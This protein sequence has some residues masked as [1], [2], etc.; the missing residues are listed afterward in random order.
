MADR[1]RVVALQYTSQD[2]GKVIAE[3]GRMNDAMRV[4]SD[5]L[6]ST[7]AR[8]AASAKA[9][10]KYAKANDAVAQSVEKVTR[11]E[12]NAAALRR[13]VSTQMPSGL[14]ARVFSQ[15]Q[16]IRTKQMAQAESDFKKL[17]AA[18]QP[19][20][21]DNALKGLSLTKLTPNLNFGGIPNQLQALAKALA[22]T[23]KEADGTTKAVKGTE[24][25]L[26]KLGDSSEASGK[27]VQ[28]FNQN[29]QQGANAMR[30]LIGGVKLGTQGINGFGFA[31]VGVLN[32]FTALIAGV[33]ALTGLMARGGNMEGISRGFKQ[34]TAGFEPPSEEFLQSL[35]DASSGTIADNE[36]MRL[37]NFAFA[38]VN[39]KALSE[40][41][42]SGL[43]ELLKIAQVQSQ[44]TGQSVDYLFQSLVTGVRRAEPRLIDNAGLIIKLSE[45]QA[46]YA[47]EVGLSVDQ[48]TSAD[49]S[50]AILNA[51]VATG[52]A[53]VEAAGGSMVTNAIRQQAVLTQLTNIANRFALAL[54]PIYKV[55][56]VGV[57]D[58]LNFIRGQA[59]SAA[60]EIEKFGA[61]VS[62]VFPAFLELVAPMGKLIYTAL[63]IPFQFLGAVGMATM[64]AL[65][66][67][68]QTV[69]VS[70]A[71]MGSAAGIGSQDPQ[72]D[73]TAAID[74][75][76]AT[77]A[78][79]AGFTS[80]GLAA[81]TLSAQTQAVFKNM[82]DGL[83]SSFRTALAITL[84]VFGQFSATIQAQLAPMQQASR[85]IGQSLQLGLGAIGGD[86]RNMFQNGVMLVASLTVE[87]NELY[88]AIAPSLMAMTELIA[89][90]GE[91]MR[92][93]F[94]EIVVSFISLAQGMNDLIGNGA[95]LTN[96]F[97][98]L[99]NIAVPVIQ[100]IGGAIQFVGLVVESVARS[101][102]RIGAVLDVVFTRTGTLSGMLQSVFGALQM[103]VKPVMAILIS[104]GALL[105]GALIVAVG[106]AG[107]AFVGLW[108]VIMFMGQPLIMFG[109][110]LVDVISGAVD[111]IL[112][113]FGTSMGEIM[114]IWS[115]LFDDMDTLGAALA[116]GAASWMGA[117]VAGILSA[118]TLVI[119]AVASMAEAIASFL[120]GESPPPT[121]PLSKIDEGG[122]NVAAAWIEGF[123]GVSLM[124]VEEVAA[125]VNYA[126]GDIGNFN[127]QQVQARLLELDTALIPFTDQ[128]AIAQSRLDSLKNPL[129]ETIGLIEDQQ[130]DMLAYL[131]EGDTTY[132]NQI[133][134]LDQQREGLRR[135]LKEQEKT[136]NQA[137]IQLTLAK[138]QQAEEKAL[139]EI[140]AARLGDPEATKTVSDRADSADRADR[141][142]AAL[143]G[144][145]GDGSTPPRDT[146]MPNPKEASGALMPAVPSFSLD[147]ADKG[148][149]EDALDPT[150][151][152]M[153]EMVTEA[154][155]TPIDAALESDGLA[156]A[157]LTEAT[158]SLKTGFAGLG[159]RMGQ[160][161]KP[162]TD[163]FDS[164]A[165]GSIQSKLSSLGTWITNFNPFSDIGG[166][167]TSVEQWAS[168]TFDPL[169]EGSVGYNISRFVV[170]TTGLEEM[171]N[172][173]ASWGE[174]FED[175]STN[176]AGAFDPNIEG[177][178]AN[179]LQNFFA[180]DGALKGLL[181]FGVDGFM[182]F[183]RKVSASFGG[184]GPMIYGMIG[185]AVVSMVN[186]LA[187][188]VNDAIT[189]FV[190]AINA[191]ILA[192]KGIL[193][194]YPS[195]AG[196]GA[197]IP[198]LNIQ[199]VAFTITLPPYPGD[200][201]GGV[202]G[203][204]TGLQAT[205]FARGGI[206][207]AGLMQVGEQGREYITTASRTAVF[208]N[209][210]VTAIESLERTMIAYNAP[211][212]AY[213]G[214]GYNNQV[215]ADNSM[216]VNFNDPTSNR[217]TVQMLNNSR[218][219]GTYRRGR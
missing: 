95:M 66:V 20:I 16:D 196:L 27:K 21:V 77:Q 130:R 23:K 172:P 207:S 218:L 94:Q 143:A 203:G 79:L 149:V 98:T 51:T 92:I 159:E 109:Q 49:R 190:E 19:T 146:L 83:V 30:S 176:T 173:F 194:R 210:F 62:F 170:Q 31:L 138:A 206:A 72:D 61:Y 75:A 131:N 70:L 59:E 216:H 117:M 54:Q 121:G 160:S 11:A 99:R 126:L 180:E 205:P 214:G 69:G 153:G 208:P 105:G 5:I 155:Q 33:T 193:A 118:K 209:S 25:A 189:K 178:S 184:F 169:V 181:Q 112:G 123:A 145:A 199:P 114:S 213:G 212:M 56:L 148:E 85:A 113:F 108:Q 133:R 97:V 1:P 185:N 164:N 3:L 183:V 87:F 219:S 17:R 28:R 47:A 132:L 202:G 55:L 200:I 93:A 14:G 188:I 13:A 167:G 90:I 91:V 158:T 53:A 182:G 48:F 68:M 156:T 163:L 103:A 198:T 29:T 122:Y 45:A 67:S 84:N 215:S 144:K 32:P 166:W 8:V 106:A 175:M 44:T 139:L 157:R 46:A 128:L 120:I 2:F 26:K 39:D 211:T 71:S 116:I 58:G 60:L 195:T 134:L 168:N 124:P 135:N 35:R 36:L 65:L 42:Q 197:S 151:E 78:Q 50:I 41:L 34:I 154:F 100:F 115:G 9:L 111:S 76:R 171:S 10:A 24:Q 177:S 82:A 141:A 18:Q 174:W 6:S 142:D 136:V 15:S 4:Q 162:L 101:F 187:A 81:D 140:Q 137:K 86:L 57:G 88:L 43:P 40:A 150:R 12:N 179:V 110:W 217:S 80:L 127:Y 204:E 201:P 186:G 107:A 63:V 152:L 64:D 119:N 74:T 125:N 165:E 96:I 89:P 102:G 192:L 129:E 37:T 191:P 22:L 52:L 104:I 147:R 7:A 73:P 38:G 161:F